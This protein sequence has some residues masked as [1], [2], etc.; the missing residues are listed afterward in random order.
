MLL[1]IN[2]ELPACAEPFL[3]HKIKDGDV[4]EMP[5]DGRWDLSAFCTCVDQSPSG[6]I[7]AKCMNLRYVSKKRRMEMEADKSVAS[8]RDNPG[9]CNKTSGKP[10]DIFR[11]SRDNIADFGGATHKH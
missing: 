10:G 9:S 6:E 1:Q 11:D 4:T 5:D 8:A 2:T 7:C 3:H